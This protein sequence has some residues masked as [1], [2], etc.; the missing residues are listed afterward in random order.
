MTQFFTD[1]LSYAPAVLPPDVPSVAVGSAMSPAEAVYGAVSALVDPGASQ[2]VSSV[3]APLTGTA[4]Y[5]AS[6]LA[7]FVGY[8]LIIFFFRGYVFGVFGLLRGANSTEKMLGE[9]SKLF[10]SFLIWTISLGLLVAALCVLRYVDG[11]FGGDITGGLP[12]W[13]GDGAVPLAWMA[14]GLIWGFQYVALK[15][16]GGITMMRGFTDNLFYLKKIIT[17]IGTVVITPFFLLWVLSDGA[18]G[19]I[20]GAVVLLLGAGL[21]IFLTVRTFMLFMRDN[22]S[23]LLWILYL[24]A[25][26][27]FPI[28][29]PVI[30]ATKVFG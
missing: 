21:A 12:R 16:A 8:C 6:V 19:R 15:V 29:L 26:E 27:I 7:C 14:A 25:V 13:A 11:R 5:D 24:C 9:Q 18:G 28:S 3:A 20:F 30:L 22:F 1:S 4:V 23:I 10:G 17:A 2:A